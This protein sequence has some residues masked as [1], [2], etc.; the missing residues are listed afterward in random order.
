MILS[1]RLYRSRCNLHLKR[2]ESLL[3]RFISASR[4]IFIREPTKR[5]CA[6]RSIPMAFSKAHGLFPQN[7]YKRTI[8]PSISS[9]APSVRAS[10]YFATIYRR[11]ADVPLARVFSCLS[12]GTETLL[13][14]RECRRS[15]GVAGAQERPRCCF[16]VLVVENSLNSSRLNF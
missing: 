5:T 2:I 4:R 3:G 13:P 14:D 15:T 9:L 6:F 16:K 7:E 1:S 11:L 12:L 8:S 10:R